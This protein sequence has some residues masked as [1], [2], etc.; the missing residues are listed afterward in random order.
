MCK[1]TTPQFMYRLLLLSLRKPSK[2]FK[3]SKNFE[4]DEWIFNHPF[5]PFTKF[6]W[7][8]VVNGCYCMF[9]PLQSSDAG[10]YILHLQI[11]YPRRLFEFFW[12]NESKLLQIKKIA[13][14]E[15]DL[16]LTTFC[17]RPFGKIINTYDH[18]RSGI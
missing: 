1:K 11:F 18:I 8:R 13:V 4:N 6:I 5:L 9:D 12:N 14:V 3:L 17:F 16:S 2:D 15:A 10:W 7:L